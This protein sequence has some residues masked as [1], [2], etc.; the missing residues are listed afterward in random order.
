MD[1]HCILQNVPRLTNLEYKRQTGNPLFV[2]RSELG[3]SIHK[4]AADSGVSASTLSYLE[5][6][7]LPNISLNLLRKLANTLASYKYGDATSD[8]AKTY[9]REMVHT[10]ADR[11]LDALDDT[12]E[13]NA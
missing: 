5:N 9:A 6:D 11:M 8:K 1:T 10:L 13:V 12:V 4:V 2:L 3:F 7:T